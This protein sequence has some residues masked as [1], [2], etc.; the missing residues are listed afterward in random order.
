MTAYLSKKILSQTFASVFS[1]PTA[2]LSVDLSI[3]VL[4]TTKCTTSKEFLRKVKFQFPSLYY[5]IPQPMLSFL[6]RE[7]NKSI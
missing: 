6:G 5:T 2:E 3:L 4:P 7:Q 1:L